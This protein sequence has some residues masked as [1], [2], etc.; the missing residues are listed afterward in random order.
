MP[1]DIGPLKPVRYTG[2]AIALHWIIAVLIAANLFLVWF[3]D[4]WPKTW[5]RP[6]IDLHKSFG[7]TVLGLVLLRVLWRIGHRPPPLPDDYPKVERWAAHAGHAVLYAL[8]FLIPLSGWIHDSAWKGAATHPLSLFG[9]VPFPRISVIM[10]ADP[11]VKERLH[12]IFFK[13]H[14]WLAYGLYGLFIIHVG[15]A[16]KHQWIDRKP[17]LQRM[18]P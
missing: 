5:T 8:I 10:S 9:V 3:V 6:V 17:E 11:A 1:E 2:V 16:L 13:A 12:D 4:D 14:Q 7:I 15:A 18:L